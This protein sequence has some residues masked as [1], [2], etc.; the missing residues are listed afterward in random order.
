MIDWNEVLDK[1]NEIVS[2]SP[3]TMVCHNKWQTSYVKEGVPH[4]CFCPY[5]TVM[6]ALGK[7]PITSDTEQNAPRDLCNVIELYDKLADGKPNLVEIGEVA[8]IF[9]NAIVRF[10]EGVGKEERKISEI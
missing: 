1:W 2:K 8:D 3:K 9:S 6:V 4:M 5:N 7:E 10:V